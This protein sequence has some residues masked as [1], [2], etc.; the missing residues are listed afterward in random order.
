MAFR[1]LKTQKF[2]LFPTFMKADAQKTAVPAVSSSRYR[3]QRT[4]N[5]LFER[6]FTACRA[7]TMRQ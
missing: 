3:D 7:G 6:G 2:R 5:K 4:V 1:T